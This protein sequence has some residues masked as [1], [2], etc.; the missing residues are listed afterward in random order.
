MSFPTIS[1]L[2]KETPKVSVK[3][4]NSVHW[5]G[6]KVR[7]YSSAVLD[8]L[9]FLV[10][11]VCQVISSLFYKKDKAKE[12]DQELIKKIEQD[13]KEEEINVSLSAS[14]QTFEDGDPFYEGD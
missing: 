6:R 3:S 8:F 5:M 13:E 10:K 9:R 7:Q 12:A 11:K 4:E 14:D 2:E 1:N